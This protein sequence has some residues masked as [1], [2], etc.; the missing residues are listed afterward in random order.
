M[1]LLFWLSLA[2]AEPVSSPAPGQALSPGQVN[3]D[4]YF[5]LGLQMEAHEQRG[6]AA[7]A[8]RRGL[9]LAPHDTEVQERL[10]LLRALPDQSPLLGPKLSG[11][12]SVLS[13]GAAFLLLAVWRMQRE[14]AWAWVALPWVLLGGGWMVLTESSLAAW[15]SQG[16]VLERAVVTSQAGEG[17]Q[18]L[19][20][21]TA[22]QTVEILAH[23]EGAIQIRTQDARVGW[24]SEQQ[25]GVLDPRAEAL[26]LR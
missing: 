15:G 13:F 2:Q 4:R 5:N 12:L 18:A 7:L 3:V 9:L 21:L 26:S 6:Q 8:Y 24:M 22:L 1:I 14:R 16:L 23:G 20:E 19:F 17:G 11:W 10:A 25:L